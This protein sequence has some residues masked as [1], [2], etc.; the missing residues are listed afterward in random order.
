MNPFEMVTIIVIAA[1]IAGVL[2]SRYKNV[3]GSGAI[4]DEARR[5]IEAQDTRI[6]RLEDRIKALEAVVAEPQFHLK[7]QF[8][9]L[10]G[11]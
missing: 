8:R 11:G 3:A 7:Q 1:L 9:D 5:H 10:E 6:A 4:S 2:R